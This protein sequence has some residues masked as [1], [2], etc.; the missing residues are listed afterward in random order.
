MRHLPKSQQAFVIAGLAFVLN[1]IF[2]TLVSLQLNL[3]DPLIG[4]S[5]REHWLTTGTPLAAP[6]PFVVAYAVFLAL[7]TRER[8]VGTVS[9]ILVSLLTLIS[10]LSLTSDWPMVQRV[11]AHHWTVG[12]ALALGMLAV[13]YPTIVVLGIV[14]LAQRVRT[15]SRPQPA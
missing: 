1:A 7:A 10:A 2:G 9:V 13:L 11:V 6:P 5:S 3:S 8:W 14:T 12:S 4:G 15:R